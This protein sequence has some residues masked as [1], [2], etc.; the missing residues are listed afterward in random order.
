VFKDEFQGAAG[1]APPAAVSGGVVAHRRR[2]RAIVRCQLTL[3]PMPEERGPRPL[4]STSWATRRAGIFLAVLRAFLSFG[5]P[6]RA[7]GGWG[8]HEL[9]GWMKTQIRAKMRIRGRGWANLRHLNK[10][11]G[12]GSLVRLVSGDALNRT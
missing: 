9:T 7:L 10:K 11:T 8:W 6:E 1:R 5:V 3:V 4:S 12:A 2:R